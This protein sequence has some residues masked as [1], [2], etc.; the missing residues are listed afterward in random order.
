MY[1]YWY[2]GLMILAFVSGIFRRMYDTRVF[3][4]A[5]R[6]VTS[7][8]LCGMVGRGR[9]SKCILTA[10]NLCRR[11]SD[12]FEWDI[13]NMARGT[14]EFI[15][16][17]VVL[18]KIVP[19]AGITAVFLGLIGC[20]FRWLE[21]T[22]REKLDLQLQDVQDEINDAVVGGRVD[23][24]RDGCGEKA[25]LYIRMS[26]YEAV[27][28][29]SCDLLGMIS[30]VVVVFALISSKFDAGEILSCVCYVWRI[31]GGVQAIGFS[32]RS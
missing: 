27:G 28:W 30:E 13:N 7:D 3:T 22:Q 21:V 32:V 19:L 1:C 12:F 24:I 8:V 6:Q 9:E 31:F 23:G 26:D 18:C 15:V 10:Q 11:F 25:G 4:G 16:G 17:S 20:W 14:V 2:V 5:W 29:G